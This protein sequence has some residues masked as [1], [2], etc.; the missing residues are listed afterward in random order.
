MKWHHVGVEVENLDN[1]IAFYEDVFGFTTDTIMKLGDEKIAFLKKDGVQIEL[2]EPE[3]QRGLLVNDL[4]HF[5]W[6]VTNLQEWITELRGKGIQPVEGPILLKNGW[7]TIFY[8]GPNKEI[9]ELIQ[10]KEVA[11]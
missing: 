3:V 5:S 1:V 8:E 7:E 10:V 11:G 4:I 2:V 9:I 6:E